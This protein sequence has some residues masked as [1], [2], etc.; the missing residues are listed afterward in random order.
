MPPV[1]DAARLR[2]L[3]QAGRKAVKLTRGKARSDLNKDEVLGLAL[4]RLLEIVGEAA[5]GLSGGFTGSHP[6][7]PW[8]S[9]TGMR[10]RLIHGYFDVDLD[11]V[12][13]TVTVELP[14]LLRKLARI[15]R[16]PR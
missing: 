4:V 7:I 5:H 13:Q 2:H 11:L 15:S 9:M 6:D 3:L 10:N 1:D 16:K 14:P 12:W 8:L